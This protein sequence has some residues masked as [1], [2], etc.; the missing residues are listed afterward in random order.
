MGGDDTLGVAT[1]C[2][3]PC[4]TSGPKTMD[5]DLN[6]DY[7]F[8]FDTSVTKAMEAAESLRTPAQPPPRWCWK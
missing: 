4:S 6:N 1:R 3:G 2:T 8:G 5:N 7:T